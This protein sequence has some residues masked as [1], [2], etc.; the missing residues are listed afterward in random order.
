VV[1]TISFRVPDRRTV[2]L[3]NVTTLLLQEVSKMDLG[4]KGKVALVTGSSSGIGR[5]TAL[6]LAEE[7][8]NIAVTGRD[9][10]RVSAVASEVKTHGVD[11]LAV[12]ADITVAED[13]KK[14]V[15]AAIDKF[16][17][18][19]ILVNSAGTSL[20]RDP[21]TLPDDEFRYEM[22]L[23]LFAVVRICT[24]VI[25]YMKKEGWGRIINISSI[26][27]KQ[28]GG[29]LDYDAIKA[30]V[31]M[32]TKDLANFLAKDNILVNAV[33]PGPIRTPLWEA[34]GAGGDQLGKALG[35]S[36]KEAIAWVA[37]Q[38]IPLGH[39]GLPEDIAGMVTFLASDKAKFI[40][41][42][43]INVDGGMVKAVI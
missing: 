34:P 30:A 42:Q 32:I 38:N 9:S 14:M 10:A 40:T 31:N 7:G 3:I 37:K 6:C 23:M 24:E 15:A 29:L 11:V 5:A 4:L 1:I 28:P 41:G 17:R 2:V 36:G 19:D 16:G 26:F 22:E 33:C 20:M 43:A 39:F 27:G 18:V 21:L 35:M 8:A 25:P 12:L 13:V